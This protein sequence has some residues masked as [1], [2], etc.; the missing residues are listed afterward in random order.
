MSS[1][2]G[3]T[4][5]AEGNGEGETQQF[6]AGEEPKKKP[7]TLL[8]AAMELRKATE[9]MDA[10]TI[11]Q[12][13]A[14]EE[15]H[16]MLREANQVQTNALM[17]AAEVAQGTR[18]TESLKTSWRPPKHYRDMTDEECDKLRAKWSILVDVSILPPHEAL[19]WLGKVT[20]QQLR[21]ALPYYVYLLRVA[22]G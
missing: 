3:G 13:K 10:A 20:T 22:C 7:R 4:G 16:R 12:M 18:Y 2:A 1:S 8:E 17:S 9:N 6:S 14:T 21:S 5:G 11:K 15:E 19:V